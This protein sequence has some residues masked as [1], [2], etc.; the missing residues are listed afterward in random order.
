MNERER[1]IAREKIQRDT[2][3]FLKMGGKIKVCKNGD[4][5]FDDNGRLITGNG[6]SYKTGIPMGKKHIVINAQKT[7][8]MRE[9]QRAAKRN[10][11]NQG[12]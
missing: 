2:E 5:A 4:T 12:R 3:A 10:Q 8:M 6:A 1:Q 11:D 7:E 9:A